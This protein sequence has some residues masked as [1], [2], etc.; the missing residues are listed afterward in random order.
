M[1]EHIPDVPGIL[2]YVFAMY[3]SVSKIDYRAFGSL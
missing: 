1:H 3:I 2:L